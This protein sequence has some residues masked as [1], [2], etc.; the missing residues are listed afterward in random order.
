MQ[1]WDGCVYNA[2]GIDVQ[3][4]KNYIV[5]HKGVKGHK[6]FIEDAE[7]FSKEADILIPAALE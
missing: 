3:E 2:Q 7:I 1:E 6:D 4:L 5:E